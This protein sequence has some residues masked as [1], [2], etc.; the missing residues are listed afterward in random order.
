[1]ITQVKGGTG[2]PLFFCH[3][4]YMMRGIY[5]HKLAALLP[6]DQPLFLLN[7]YAGPLAGSSIEEI[8]G[9]YLQEVRRAAPDSPVFVGGYCNGGIA[10]WHL[11][12]LLRSEGVDVVE[13]LLVE[14]ISLNARPELRQLGRLFEWAGTVVP[15]RAGRFL[16]EEAMRGIWTWTRRLAHFNYDTARRK[17]ISALRLKLGPGLPRDV[18]EEADLAY[19]GL[20][21]RY[22]PP[23]LDR[24]VTCFIAEQGRHFDTDPRLW[25]GLAAELS[26]V[27]M[28]GTHHTS[29][30]SHRQALA[31]VL[32]RVLERATER[33][34]RARAPDNSS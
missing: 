23:P 17:I 34:R 11:A 7:C 29:I 3:G 27:S 20:M 9:A 30:I 4:D 14:T 5:A 28:P 1:V 19:L 15:G 8:A 33:Y 6:D 2:I 26:Q 31:A 13:L 10:A 25:H 21:A 22:I 24:P 18:F 12:H 32:A 16:R